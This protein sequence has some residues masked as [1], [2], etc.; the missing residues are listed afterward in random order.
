[1][2][3][4]NIRV[5]ITLVDQAS[6]RARAVLGSLQKLNTTVRTNVIIEGRDRL[7][8]LLTKFQEAIKRRKPVAVTMT[9][10]DKFTADANKAVDKF[11][12]GLKLT[13]EFD[14]FSKGLRRASVV[15][16]GVVIGITAAAAAIGVL[17]AIS[18]AKFI[19]QS[20]ELNKLFE[21][22]TVQLQTVTGSLTA[23]KNE[24]KEIVEYAKQTPYAIEDVTAAVVR[25]RSYMMDTDEWLGPLGDMAAAFGRSITNAV[26]AAADASQGQFRRMIEYGIRMERAMFKEGGKYAGKTYAEAVMQEITTRFS[27]GMKLQSQTFVG[28]TSN[29][30]DMMI[31][32]LK[33]LGGPIFNELKENAEK[34]FEA[35]NS[36]EFTAALATFIEDFATGFRKAKDALML[37]VEYIKNNVLPTF[38][39][40]LETIF[41]AAGAIAKGFVDSPFTSV[42]KTIVNQ[43][44][45]LVDGLAGVIRFAAPLLQ[46]YA[47]FRVF[48]GILAVVGIGLDKAAAGMVALGEASTLTQASV[49]ILGK[50]LLWVAAIFAGMQLIMG[51]RGLSDNI[52]AIGDSLEGIQGNIKKGDLE[53]YFNKIGK[54]TNY[55]TDEAAEA[56]RVATQFGNIGANVLEAAAAAARD[57]G[58]DLS[59]AARIIGEVSKD[60]ITL[61]MSTAE[62]ATKVKETGDALAYIN[63]KSKDLKISQ[64]D[65]LAVLDKYP[66]LLNNL[67]NGWEDVISTLNSLSQTSKNVRKDF[68][69]FAETIDLLKTPDAEMFRYLDASIWIGKSTAELQDYSKVISTATQDNVEYFKSMVD[70]GKGLQE[71]LDNY[72]QLTIENTHL[73]G[74][75]GKKASYD[76]A[77]AQ[78]A[79]RLMTKQ[80]E[81]LTEDLEYWNGVVED[82]S[83]KLDELEDELSDISAALKEATDDVR[84]FTDM[85]PT[86]TIAF[87]NAIADLGAEINRLTLGTL[88]LD[89]EALNE[90]F[91][92]QERAIR[93][94][95]A[96]IAAMKVS[97]KPLENELDTVKAQ[98][99]AVSEAIQQ[100]QKDLDKFTNPKLKGMEEFD[101]KI[102]A[103]EMELKKLQRQRL[104]AAEKV[105]VFDRLGLTGTEA[106][107]AVSAELA[108][109]DKLIDQKNSQLDKLNLDRQLAFDDQLYQLEKIGDREQEITFEEA[110]AGANAAVEAL[111]KLEPQLDTLNE[112]QER[113][114]GIV[115]SRQDEIDK[116]EEIVDARQ[117]E[118]DLQKTAIENAREE[119]QLQIDRLETMQEILTISREIE[120]ADFNRQ[121]ENLLNPVTEGSP[122]DILAGLSAALEESARLTTIE[123]DLQKQIDEATKIK[124]YAEDQV[125][126]LDG[127]RTDLSGQMKSILKYAPDLIDAINIG[128][129]IA[130]T[131]SSIM[132]ELFGTDIRSVFESIDD[133]IAL[134]VANG[135]IPPAGG[136]Q[137]ERGWFGDLTNWLKNTTVGNVVGLAGGAAAAYFGGKAGKATINKMRGTGSTTGGGMIE[138]LLKGQNTQAINAAEKALT[139]TTKAAELEAQI[140]GLA[141]KE[142][143]VA[144][145]AYQDAIKKGFTQEEAYGLAIDATKNYGKKIEK[146]TQ[147]LDDISYQTTAE[148]QALARRY[149]R[150]GTTGGTT[151]VAEEVAEQAGKKGGVF[152]RAINRTFGSIPGVQATRESVAGLGDL[153][154]GKN[155]HTSINRT[156]Y[157]ALEAG[158]WANAASKGEAAPVIKRFGRVSV[159]RQVQKRIFPWITRGGSSGA[160]TPGGLK[161]GGG[162]LGL[163]GMGLLGG[164]LGEG[165]GF[166]WGSAAE[167]AA[168]GGTYMGMEK[169][170]TMGLTKA[171]GMGASKAIPLVGWAALAGDALRFGEGM[172][173][174]RFGTLGKTTANTIG[175]GY[176]SMLDKSGIPLLQNLKITDLDKISNGVENTTNSITDSLGN[177][178][179]V[180]GGIVGSAVGIGKGF[181]T[182]D[183]SYLEDSGNQLWNGVKQ[184]PENVAK[185]AGN[186]V[187]TLAETGEEI[188]DKTTKPFQKGY[189]WLRNNYKPVQVLDDKVLGPMRNW[190]GTKYAG[191]KDFLTDPFNKA[192]GW[193][194]KEG[195]LSGIKD[196]VVGW[197]QGIP[198]WFSD[199]NGAWG[200]L[201]GS[202]S[203]V[204]SKAWDWLTGEDGPSGWWNSITDWF[205]GIADWFSGEDGIWQKLK[206][207]I[208]NRLLMRGIG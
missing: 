181:F 105:S 122:S 195:G 113:L 50:R 32:A 158:N 88:Q 94:L 28:L 30:K 49:M 117:A 67:Q 123:A 111:D 192:K 110:V 203:G 79:Y 17:T 74:V 81:E 198:D 46:L 39:T 147:Q 163:L 146:L 178:S 196:K 62:A 42:L 197:F 89:L 144:V 171:L 206:G 150:T 118:L 68:Y 29:I 162:L 136:A 153:L 12:R 166:N 34:I 43:V 106:Y 139:T 31:V 38:K 72:A 3:Q 179:D 37:I 13:E 18:M 188:F 155:P 128:N 47:T 90:S 180:V 138:D 164:A 56:G 114:Q 185:A 66:S 167:T 83:A 86:G 103:T 53:E 191:V 4:N 75:F 156:L 199:E 2:N 208:G 193:F 85:Q 152:Q 23:A 168:F 190:F 95:N 116:M 154:A 132:T 151:Q 100:A 125:G 172:M 169:L 45:A 54:A 59:T 20:V 7:T 207:S 58:K 176:N 40:L 65:V 108:A 202:I 107:K 84:K 98:F 10:N 194:E 60:M 149:N 99:E 120:L 141:A 26:E 48:S 186:T 71:L 134:L 8:P 109:I 78:E 140:A 170:G 16:D 24:L 137:E 77:D 70:S 115:D 27:G 33:Q 91:A 64:D 19:K 57:M 184:L 124:E 143:Q 96:E 182:G 52:N 126:E 6:A 174:Q 189:D 121:R 93:A 92:Q 1:M 112:E 145:K 11:K 175:G 205:S 82:Q 129:V 183:W 135:G 97:L 22:Y 131:N 41:T 157:N 55:A 160:V 159:G 25:L 80:V 63:Q 204:F 21:T 15:L 130:T 119:L 173:G 76:I 35:L 102:H 51:R 142:R 9:A 61:E 101:D 201:T 200:K 165:E 127:L 187:V 5:A 44:L 133:N 14:K 73:T 177:V 36:P 161:G 104:D 87:Q 148:E 69:L